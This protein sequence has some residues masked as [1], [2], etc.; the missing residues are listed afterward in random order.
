MERA[1]ERYTRRGQEYTDAQI[2]AHIERHSV[3]HLLDS[4]PVEDV[5]TLINKMDKATASVN[6][7]LKS[8]N[9]RNTLKNVAE[10]TGELKKTVA[11]T[12]RLIENREHSIKITL[13]NVQVITDDLREFMITL[14]NYPSWVLFG[15]PPPRFIQD[16]EEEKEEEQ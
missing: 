14:K 6:K 4:M 9:V 12:N 10:T 5:R 11:K 13:D 16:I 7:I 3:L 15:N 1:K 2:A 8:E